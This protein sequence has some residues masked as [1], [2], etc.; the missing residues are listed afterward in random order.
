MALFFLPATT[1][2]TELRV[3]TIVFEDSLTFV[4]CSSKNTMANAWGIT[5]VQVSA[6]SLCRNCRLHLRQA[7]SIRCGRQPC[8]QEATA[9]SRAPRSID[10]ALAPVGPSEGVGTPVMVTPP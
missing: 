9:P 3:A 1:R 2:G 8:G 7:T 4:E 10:E 5:P 6:Y